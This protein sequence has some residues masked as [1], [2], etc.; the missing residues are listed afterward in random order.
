MNLSS[1]SRQ[2]YYNRSVI[3]ALIYQISLLHVDYPCKLSLSLLANSYSNPDPPLQ[4][5]L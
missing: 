3:E 1:L 2:A 4:A 5:L